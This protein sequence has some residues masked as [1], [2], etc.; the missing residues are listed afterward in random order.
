[1]YLRLVQFNLG[2][3]ARPAADKIARSVMTLIRAQ[4][5]CERATFFADDTS[6]DSGLAVLWA[7][8]RDADAAA[9]IVSPVLMKALAETNA[10]G[11]KPRL[12]E[13][14]EPR[15]AAETSA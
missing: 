12:F 4:P 15:A 2:S 11:G 1:M 8:R 3:P 6:G 9:A 5:G 14:L 10:T 13:V 7:T